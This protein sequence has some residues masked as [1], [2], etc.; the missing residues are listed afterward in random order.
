MEVVE[1]ED[2]QDRGHLVA[3]L[4]AEHKEAGVEQLLAEVAACTHH[5]DPNRMAAL[6]LA[7]VDLP[8]TEV[9]YLMYLVVVAIAMA[10]VPYPEAVVEVENC[11][12]SEDYPIHHLVVEV[13]LA[14]STASLVVVVAELEEGVEIL[15]EVASLAARALIHWTSTMVELLVA[16]ARVVGSPSVV[17]QQLPWVEMVSYRTNCILDSNVLEPMDQQQVFAAVELDLR[18]AQPLNSCILRRF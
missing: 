1:E 18:Q 7:A 12:E 6:Y 8:K 11:Q 4:V 9:V 17:V 5:S 15:G 2:V 14:A 3:R 10:L 16:A 13:E